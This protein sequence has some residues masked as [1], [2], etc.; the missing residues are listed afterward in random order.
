MFSEVKLATVGVGDLDRAI[1]FY[2]DA[3]AL[4]EISRTTVDTDAVS[5]AWR[6]P[7]GITGR[8]AVMGIPGN[9]SGMLRLVEWQPVGDHV[10]GAPA[11]FQDYGMNGLTFRVR[12]INAAWDNLCRSGARDRMKPTYW[13]LEQNLC[14]WTADATDHDGTALEIFEVV[15]EV[16]D[17]LGPFRTGRDVT[18][19]Q[20]VTIHSSDARRSS[21]F[22][23]AL[24]FEAL[25]DRV[26]EQAWALLDL[27]KGTKLQ[28]VHLIRPGARSSGRIEI[29]HYIGMPGRTLKSRSTPPA[30]GPLMM[31]IRVASLDE[32]CAK[33]KTQGAKPIGS[34]RYNSPPFGNVSAA[35]F[36]G[37]DDEVIELFEK[38]A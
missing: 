1:A 15:G 29:C 14:P 35:T 13:E 19:V 23:G 25:Y 21:A 9:E 33:V 24:G 12:E 26:I 20:A 31:S 18:E 36:F 5:E 34:A 3:F 38:I 28:S 37:P 7:A 30:R 32:A 10:R 17:S 4:E 22:Y 16:A 27:P 8:Y 6:I 2:A 11:R